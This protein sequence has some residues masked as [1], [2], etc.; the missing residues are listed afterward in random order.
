MAGTPRRPR[1]AAAR[2]GTARRLPARGAIRT[3]RAAGGASGNRSGRQQRRPR[4][5]NAAADGLLINGS[6]NNGAASPFAQRAFG[7]NRPGGRG[8]TTA[9][10]VCSRATR[11]STR[12][13]FVQRP[14]GGEAAYNDVHFIANFGGPIP[15]ASHAPRPDFFGNYQHAERRHDAV[16]VDA[17]RARTLRRLFAD[18]QRLRQPRS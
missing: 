6:V 11:R 13:R 10:S 16:G 15:S 1:P 2:T 3:R 7:N 5:N 18:A 8:S 17:H 12:G 4:D 14:A 9:A